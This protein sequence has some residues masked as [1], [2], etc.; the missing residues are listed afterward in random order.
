MKNIVVK[1]TL[2]YITIFFSS[3]DT[4]LKIAQER[5]KVTVATIEDFVHGM[6]A[7]SYVSCVFYI[8]RQRY[9]YR[10]YPTFGMTYGEKYLIEYDS[11]YTDKQILYREKP[12][13]LPDEKTK[14]TIGTL[15]R[16]H[17]NYELIGFNYKV[18][19]IE[20]EFEKVQILDRQVKNYPQ[21]VNG[22]KFVVEY[23]E[24]NPQRAIIYIDR[25]IKDSIITDKPIT[26]TIDEINNMQ[27]RS[28]VPNI[29]FSYLNG[30]WGCIGGD[31]MY[32]KSLILTFS[33]SYYTGTY[34]AEQYK[35]SYNVYEKNFFIVPE[36]FNRDTITISNSENSK[37]VQ[38]KRSK[39]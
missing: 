32:S 18:N 39:L 34:E 26:S 27:L 15:V 5:K 37:H 7:S 20:K 23:W 11:L 2:L 16:V 3:C 31:T 1:I 12:V 25:P 38:F 8:N 33:K 4:E 6:H 14:F 35:M 9:E 21:L 28:N 13:F 36:L 30:E 10:A 19:S 29:T 17:K 24:R 22:A